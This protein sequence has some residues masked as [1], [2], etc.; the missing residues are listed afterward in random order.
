M[1]ARNAPVGANHYSRTG[2]MNSNVTTKSISAFAS[3][4]AVLEAK[5]PGESVRIP[6]SEMPRLPLGFSR[7]LLGTPLWIAHP[8]S[9]AQYRAHS[10]VHAYEMGHSWDV[11]RDQYDPNDNPFEH[12]LFDAPELPIAAVLS[13]IAGVLTYLLVAH[14]EEEKPGE[15]RHWWM[16]LLV[17]L[18]VA[19]LVGMAAYIVG[20]LLRVAAGVG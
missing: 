14:R 12:A 6:K 11:H 19:A 18:A 15:E 16:S 9:T 17:S 20:A 5:Q 7:T 8:G 3:L 10:A 2:G 13:A 4:R 1:H